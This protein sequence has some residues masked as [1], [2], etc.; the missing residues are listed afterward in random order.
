MGDWLSEF[1][2]DNPELFSQHPEA[3]SE[4]ESHDDG[5]TIEVVDAFDDADF[6]HATLESVAPPPPAA[7]E[8]AL[9]PEATLPEENVPDYYR[10]YVDALREVA[11]SF[12]APAAVVAGMALT[13]EADPVARMWRV[14]INGGEPDFSSC[15]QTLDEWSA[16]VVARLA[17]APE[18]MVDPIRR[19]LRSRGV[20]AFGLVVEAA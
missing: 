8:T 10:M 12:G 20:C 16:Q 14:A 1:P 3:I 5:L 15:A 11:T 2:N 9:E 18:A 19:A 6:E 17:D 7:V 4:E 13:L